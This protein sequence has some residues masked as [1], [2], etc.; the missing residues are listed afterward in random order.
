MGLPQA[1]EPDERAIG[2]EPGACHLQ[3]AG[4]ASPLALDLFVQEDE[5]LLPPLQ[6][7]RGRNPGVEQGLADVPGQDRIVRPVLLGEPGH[8]VAEAAD[9]TQD[10]LL[11][12]QHG[13]DLQPADLVR[14]LGPRSQAGLNGERRVAFGLRQRLCS[15]CPSMSR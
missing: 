2:V 11:P 7:N 6:A 12:P 10:L 1:P 14:E 13:Q 5:G 15:R 9:L 4:A 3:A 8:L